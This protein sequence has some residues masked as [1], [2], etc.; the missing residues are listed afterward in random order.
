MSLKG[1]TTLV[2]AGREIEPQDRLRID[3]V[4]PH[5][6]VD[7][8]L[9]R[10]HH[11]LLRGVDVE[12]RRQRK[13]P[14]RLG[15]RVELGEPA[16]EHQGQPPV[17]VMVRLERQ[18]AGREAR[19]RQRIGVFHMGAGARIEPAEIGLDEIRVPD[20]ALGIGAHVMG[21]DGR[22]RHVVFGDDHPGRPAGRARQRLQLVVPAVG[23]AQID[24]RK[25]LG[26]LAGAI[27][28]HRALDHARLH[29]RH[30]RIVG[31][32]RHALEHADELVGGELRAH[33][34]LERVAAHAFDQRPLLLG[35]ARHAHEPFGAGELAGNIRDLRQREI[36]LRRPLCADIGARRRGE[37]IADGADRQRIMSGSEPI[38]G[39]A[40]AA[41][42]VGH[43][44]DGERRAVAPGAD[45]H[46][47]HRA[48]LRRRDAAG[49]RKPPARRN[50]SPAHTPRPQCRSE[51]NAGHRGRTSHGNSES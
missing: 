8:G 49:Q 50:S 41:G 35:R 47:F 21:R 33:H 48:F 15:L 30:R 29:M 7:V 26:D 2:V 46:A 13:E 20:E 44:R 19:L 14:E 22:A 40:V 27:V 4:G 43:D 12:L 16:L 10:H 42:G 6:A 45:Q 37:L 28:G 38:G 11:G 39:K 36:G 25:I 5:L 32:V 17:A 34:P 3:V 1:S 23:L 18:R 24:G 9:A 51:Q 31:E